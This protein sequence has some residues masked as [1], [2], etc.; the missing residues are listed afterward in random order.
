MS[1]GG[2]TLCRFEKPSRRSADAGVEI[3]GITKKLQIPGELFAHASGPG[4]A[5]IFAEVFHPSSM[6]T[7]VTPKTLGFPWSCEL[8]ANPLQIGLQRFEAHEIVHHRFVADCVDRTIEW[9]GREPDPLGKRLPDHG[10]IG[11]L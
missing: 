1:P 6:F 4:R 3:A 9:E 2:G 7:L 10:K 11:A 8:P 5:V